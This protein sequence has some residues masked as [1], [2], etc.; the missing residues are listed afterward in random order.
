VLLITIVLVGSVMLVM[1]VV[2]AAKLANVSG[3]V[4]VMKVVFD[5]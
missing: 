1:P 4:L 2:L 3:V 5:T